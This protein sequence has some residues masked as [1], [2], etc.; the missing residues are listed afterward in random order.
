MGHG[1]NRLPYSFFVTTLILLCIITFPKTYIACMDFTMLG[2]YINKKAD[3]STEV[4]SKTRFAYDLS[5]LKRH[6]QP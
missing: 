1:Q 4:S 6:L 5:T 3:F 2:V